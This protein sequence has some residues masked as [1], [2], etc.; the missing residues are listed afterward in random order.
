MSADPGPQNRFSVFRQSLIYY[1][2][3]KSHGVWPIFFRFNTN[4][5]FCNSLDNFA[6]R[7]NPIWFTPI[8]NGFSYRSFGFCYHSEYFWRKFLF[9]SFKYGR[10]TFKEVWSPCLIIFLLIYL[11]AFKEICVSA[12]S[13]M[14][15]SVDFTVLLLLLH[16]KWW[17]KFSGTWLFS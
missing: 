7:K 6:G 15:H 9:I 4:I 10:T 5:N 12:G 17:S 8:V 2:R 13:H 14:S 3:S 1:L 16:T 11:Y